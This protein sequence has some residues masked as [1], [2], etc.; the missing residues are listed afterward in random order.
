MT[1][2]TAPLPAALADRFALGRVRSCAP[3]T[4]GLMN[5]SWRLETTVGVFAVKQVRDAT[6]A[7]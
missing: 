3:I 6:P 1:P 5:P 4:Q 2:M 7:S